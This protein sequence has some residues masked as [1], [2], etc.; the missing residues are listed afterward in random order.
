MTR[1][2]FSEP[3][4]FVAAAADMAECEELNPLGIP[5][6]AF[7]G[8]S[9]VGKSSLLNALMRTSIVNTSKHPGRTKGL[10]FFGVGPSVVGNNNNNNSGLSDFS[11]VA[12]GGEGR[13]DPSTR[14][15]R[16]VDLPGYGYA[17]VSKDTVKDLHRRVYDY[18]FTRDRSILMHVFILVDVRRGQPS[19]SDLELMRAM[20]REGVRYRVVL[21]KMDTVTSDDALKQA[22]VNTMH[23]TL[24]NLA[25]DPYVSVVS[26]K[27]GVGVEELRRCIGQLV[28][29]REIVADTMMRN[30]AAQQAAAEQDG[31]GH[32]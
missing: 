17:R 13:I 26:A 11:G 1:A 8:K 21:T 19:D 18:L 27:F 2:L 20:D 12:G 15:L 25:C 30:M 3:G 5:E 9:N 24:K 22:V 31:D 4:D 10:N 23:L 28:A 16:L 14:A 7:V 29:E 32:W 6:I